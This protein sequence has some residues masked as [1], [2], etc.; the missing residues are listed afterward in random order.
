MVLQL[1]DVHKIVGPGLKTGMPFDMK[2]REVG[3]DRIVN[4]VS[5]KHQSDVLS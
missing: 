3:A 4:A 5:A 1:F 2:T